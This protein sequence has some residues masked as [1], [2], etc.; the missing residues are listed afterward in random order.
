[1]AEFRHNRG[2]CIKAEA[3]FKMALALRKLPVLLFQLGDSLFALG[4]HSGT[5]ASIDVSPLDPVAQSLLAYAQ[6]A[7][8][9]LDHAPALTG[10]LLDGLLDHANGRSRISGG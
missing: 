10:C 3:D 1:M 2:L 8:H 7:S 6:L 5:P 9:S 4:G